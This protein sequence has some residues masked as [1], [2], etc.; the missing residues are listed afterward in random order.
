MTKEKEQ[1]EN[2]RFENQFDLYQAGIGG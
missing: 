2:L 1:A